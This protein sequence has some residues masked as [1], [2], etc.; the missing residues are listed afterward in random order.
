MAPVPWE[1]VVTINRALCQ[2]QKMDPLTHPQGLEAA[3]QVWIKS[4]ERTMELQEAFEICHAAHKASPFV[5]NNGNT[6]AAVGHTLAESLL[7]TLPPLEAQIFRTTIGHYI[8]GLIGRRELQQVL[9]HLEPLLQQETAPAT[10]A[11]A[12]APTPAAP[13]PAPTPT[14]ATAV[15]LGLPRRQGA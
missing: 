11:P 6:F 9:K 14:P 7:R 2:A 8:C 1:S 3:R 5:F 12:P 4:V 10:A 13:A 15:S